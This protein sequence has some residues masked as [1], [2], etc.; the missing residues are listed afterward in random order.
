MLVLRTFVKTIMFWLSEGKEHLEVRK[1]H[2]ILHVVFKR[3]DIFS[4]GSVY[5]TLFKKLT[6]MKRVSL[7]VNKK[8]Y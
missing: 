1:Y 4:I 3:V 7:T 8:R 5:L 2:N 6:F